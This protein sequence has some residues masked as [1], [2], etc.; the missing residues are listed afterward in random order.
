MKS[1]FSITKIDDI[2]LRKY[3]IKLSETKKEIKKIIE[4]ILNLDELKTSKISNKDI[5]KICFDLSFC[6]DETIHQINKEYRY[7]DCPTDVITFSLFCDDEN[8]II[9]RKT[10]DLGQIIISIETANRQKEENKNTLKKE[11]L[12]LITHGILHL[13]GFDHLT[14]KDYDFVVGVQNKVLSKYE[15]ISI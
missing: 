8:A 4:I 1:S 11:I 6:N 5:T 2:N 3:Q 7:K 12:T 9:Y 14:K 10:A 13:F 15:Q